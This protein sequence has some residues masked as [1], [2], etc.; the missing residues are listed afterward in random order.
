MITCRLTR[1][2]ELKKI[3]ELYDYLKRRVGQ[4]QEEQL[5]YLSKGN[6]VVEE[7]MGL[8]DSGW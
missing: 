2:I 1:I 3:W 4:K 6:S 8:V 7:G 5:S